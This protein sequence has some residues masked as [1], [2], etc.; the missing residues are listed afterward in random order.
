MRRVPAARPAL[1]GKLKSFLRI[2]SS[3]VLELPESGFAEMIRRIEKDPLFSKLFYEE[4]ILKL[5]RL[6]R[7]SLATGLH[8]MLD[9][10]RAPGGAVD[11]EKVV[12]SRGQA[13][14]AVRKLGQ[15]NFEKYFLYNE[16]NY[17]PAEIARECALEQAE[18]ESVIELMNTVS[19]H[20]EFQYQ[21]AP[22]AGGS[23][24]KRV[25][26]VERTGEG[27]YGIKFYSPQYAR[28]RYEYN[29]DAVRGLVDRGV[30]GN[31]EKAGLSRLLSLI[32]MVND[33]KSTVYGILRTLVSRQRSYFASGDEARLEPFSQ[34]EL[35]LA[36]GVQESSVSRAIFGRSL[37][38]P[39][40][41]EKPLKFFCPSR[42]TMAKIYIRGIL[43]GGA[44][45]SD[46]EL[47]LALERLHGLKLARRTVNAYRNEA[48]GA[49]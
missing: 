1:R 47:G 8:E 38:T 27:E 7:A 19:L 36:A 26:A 32:E 23:S 10:V 16:G 12:E 20:E 30:I 3:D 21:A 39:G 24:Y 41:E 25:A 44:K 42:K 46:G 37:V 40:G 5:R 49:R 45:M 31:E 11:V 18:V 43:S 14:A 4:K 13:T 2:K 9:N 34:K 22:A 6:P 15:E 35:A 29:K 28:G 17:T 48:G 33:R